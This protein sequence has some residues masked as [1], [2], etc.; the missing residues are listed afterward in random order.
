V[1]G[2]LGT[3]KL[4]LKILINHIKT[5]GLINIGL[6]EQVKAVVMFLACTWELPVPITFPPLAILIFLGVP[7]S[8]KR[9]F[10]THRLGNEHFFPHSCTP[11]ISTNDSST[12]S[13]SRCMHTRIEDSASR[14]QYTLK[15]IEVVASQSQYTLI[16]IQSVTSQSQYTLNR[17]Q[18]VASQSQY[19]LIRIQGVASQSLYTLIRIQGVA[20]QSQY[21]LIRIQCRISKSVHT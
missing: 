12:S 13:K 3:A 7:Q 17:I 4:M 20:S 6:T 19:T 14:S 10:G 16:R 18:D 9:N 21:T 1:Q 5:Y 15:R 8:G 11:S 2:R